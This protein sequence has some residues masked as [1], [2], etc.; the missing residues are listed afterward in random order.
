MGSVDIDRPQWFF[1]VSSRTY[2]RKSSRPCPRPRLLL[3]HR[4]DPR[5][6]AIAL[7]DH[8]FEECAEI[9]PCSEAEA[10]VPGLLQVKERRSVSTLFNGKT[11]SLR[12]AIA[13]SSN[14]EYGPAVGAVGS[15]VV[16]TYVSRFVDRPLVAPPE[17]FDFLRHL[18]LLRHFRLQHFP[19]RRRRFQP[20]LHLRSEAP[21]LVRRNRVPFHSRRLRR[22]RQR[23]LRPPRMSVRH[24]LAAT[25]HMS[26]LL[27][28]IR[29]CRRGTA[30]LGI[31][32]IGE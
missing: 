26:A 23:S 21:H 8:R 6:S 7:S 16:K 13:L 30:R 1:S 4:P 10:T 22:R 27:L 18:R 5:A 15:L 17:A 2:V 3:R 28:L 25:E 32:S 12:D 31:A 9:R 24:W 29:R 11:Q 14:V 19:R 20:L